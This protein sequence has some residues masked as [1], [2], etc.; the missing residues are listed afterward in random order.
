MRT[1]MTPTR[2]MLIA[3]CLAVPSGLA[4]AGTFAT[5]TSDG[6]FSDWAAVPVAATDGVDGTPIDFTELKLANDLENLYVLLTF[7]TAVNPQSGS[8]TF[9]AV[10]TDSDFDTGFNIFGLNVVGSNLGFQNDFAFTQTSGSFNSEGTVTGTNYGASPYNASTLQ[11]EIAIPLTTF[12]TD[13]SAGGFTGVVFDDSFSIAFYSTDGGGDII[14]P[15]EP[16]T[17]AA[18]EPASL[19]LLSIGGLALLGRR[20]A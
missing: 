14:S 12:Q 20:R 8:G 13:P 16:Y 4:S 10:D 17:L 3:A 6:D 15:G 7:A 9:T 5:I 18:P 2:G 1:M 11:Q 19:V